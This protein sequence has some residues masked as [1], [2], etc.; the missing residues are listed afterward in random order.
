MAVLRRL[1]ERHRN[2]EL[3]VCWAVKCG[4]P[5]AQRYLDVHENYY[6]NQGPDDL[7]FQM[8]Y[9]QNSSF[10]PCEKNMSQVWFEFTPSK[11]Q[12]AEK[13]RDYW[14]MWFTPGTRDYRYGFM[15]ALS[16]GVNL[17]FM[18][19]LPTFKSEKEKQEYISFMGKW[20]RW[21]SKN[22]SYLMVKRDIFGQPLRKG[23]IDGNARILNDRGFVFIF[24]PT[25]ARH[26]G[27]I[28]LDDRI[29]LRARMVFEVKL[30]FPEDGGTLGTY[31][32][33]QQLL[34]DMPPGTCKL[35]EISPH[36]GKRIP[37]VVPA[38]VDI[39]DAF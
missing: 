19:Q 25:E 37:A 38:G 27:R 36:L 24:N 15:S 26:I 22:L 28:P 30:I 20:K 5:W 8:W 4:G 31:E 7:R 9:N 18:V 10:L 39:Q 29:R 1:R 23:G 14:K 12:L 33:G 11:M 34:V 21:A 32:H 35:L 17:V 6:E 3:G 2:V 16:A 13:Q